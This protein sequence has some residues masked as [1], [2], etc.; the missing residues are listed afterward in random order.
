VP[1]QLNQEINMNRTTAIIITI[2][3]ALLC[4]LPGLLLIIFGGLAAMGSQVPEVVAESNGTAEQA[5]L[6]AGVFLCFGAI[7]MVFPVIVGF[8][9]IGFA[10]KSEAA[11]LEQ[12]PM[13]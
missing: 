8:L 10:K 2:V 6:G 7:L 13:V 1:D 4:G 5:L 12:K 9:T 3:S 11:A